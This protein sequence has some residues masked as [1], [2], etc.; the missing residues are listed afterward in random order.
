MKIVDSKEM[1]VL[2][3]DVP[4]GVVYQKPR[5][6]WKEE[7]ALR[8]VEDMKTKVIPLLEKKKWV[9]ISDVR[10][11][12]VSSITEILNELIAY[13][14]QKGQVGG[15]IIVESALVKMQLTRSTKSS[16]IAPVVFTSEEEAEA[17]LKE[18]GY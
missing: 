15:G 5:G 8:F 17:W 11:Y 10:E 6:F 7:D 9:V 12:K 16:E 14:H 18:Q 2:N 1:Y 3:V 13:S 4:R